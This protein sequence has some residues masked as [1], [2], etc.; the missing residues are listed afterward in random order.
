MLYGVVMICEEGE[1]WYD[2][3]D[4]PTSGPTSPAPPST[5]SAETK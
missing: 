3:D 2:Y 1:E 5:P 4:D